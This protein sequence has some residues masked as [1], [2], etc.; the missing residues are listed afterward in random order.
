MVLVVWDDK[1]G[2]GAIGVSST[3]CKIPS[4]F[5]CKQKTAY[6]MRISDWSSDVCS[7]DL[8][9]CDGAACSC[10]CWHIQWPASRSDGVTA[11]SSGSASS[12]AARCSPS[13]FSRASRR[14]EPPGADPAVHRVVHRTGS[15]EERGEG[16]ERV[17][18]S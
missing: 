4:L 16:N 18:E 1:L 6:E 15:T 17:S 10:C 9:A 3:G 2:H 7:S 12:A 13:C 11:R 8:V 5:F 14:A